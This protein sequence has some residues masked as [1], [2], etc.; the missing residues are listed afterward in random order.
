MKTKIRWFLG[1]ILIL[2][3]LTEYLSTS[4][5]GAILILI[6]GLFILPLSGNIFFNKLRLQDNTKAKWGIVIVLWTLGM[7]ALDSAG[8]EKAIDALSQVEELIN[9]G[10]INEA[11]QFLNNNEKE[12]EFSTKFK[13]LKLRVDKASDKDFQQISLGKMTDDEFKLLEE[14]KLEKTYFESK[15]LNK[16]FIAQLY[17]NR[18]ERD[19]LLANKG[20]LLAEED[21][22]TKNILSQDELIKSIPDP[23]DGI[24]RSWFGKEPTLVTKW[25]K[26]EF[27]NFYNPWFEYV[28]HKKTEYFWY[29]GFKYAALKVWFSE[30]D[31]GGTFTSYLV[32]LVGGDNKVLGIASYKR[33]AMIGKT[34]DTINSEAVVPGWQNIYRFPYENRQDLIK[35]L[36]KYERREDW[37]NYNLIVDYFNSLKN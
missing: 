4:F 31:E 24:E 9:A 21:D 36:K 37:Y 22:H 20:R 11:K 8:D 1:V 29:D 19:S 35:E 10:A 7:G 33:K 6:S 25:I 15:A 16:Y 2:I 34:R 27:K 30:K 13:N 28:E 23:R 18:A 12:N 26:E 17:G 3:S 32:L 5:L 14:N